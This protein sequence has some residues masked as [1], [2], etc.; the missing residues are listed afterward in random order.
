[1]ITRVCQISA[2]VCSCNC[3][4]HPCMLEAP[5]SPDEILHAAA[6]QLIQLADKLERVVTIQRM[7]LQPLAMGNNGYA[8][9]VYRTR[10]AYQAAQKVGA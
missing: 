6:L 9:E 3:G 4:N 7:P 5:R 8:V 10:S 2:I 1:M